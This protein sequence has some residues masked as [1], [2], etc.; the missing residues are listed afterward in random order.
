[1]KQ[2]PDKI[3]VTG[4]A[5]FI[6]STL[7]DS[8]LKNGI[9]VVGIDNFSNLYDPN[10]KR[11]NI[12]QA[13]NRKN[14]TLYVEDILNKDKMFK[15]VSRESPGIVVHIAG[16]TG[17]KKSLESPEEF[18]QT[19]VTGTFNILEVCRKSGISKFIYASTAT[20]Y[21]NSKEKIKEDSNL[22]EPLNTY[23]LTKKMG[24]DLVRY[25]ALNYQLKAM[26]LRLSTVYGP[27]QRTT[28]GIS[29]FVRNIDKGNE[30]SLIGG[31]TSFRDY[32]FIDDCV[33][34]FQL[35]I[36]KI[37]N[38]DII[39]ICGKEVI[40][41][42][43]LIGICAKLLQKRAIIKINS[44]DYGIPDGIL[45]DKHKAEKLLGYSPST[46]FIDGLQK[47]IAYY[48]LQN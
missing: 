26:V 19:N 29:T 33:N 37:N 39:N 45:M 17:M 16:L 2:I 10:I 28:M 38:F 18:Y 4:A 22:P 48:K 13:V 12:R 30:I 8:L 20:V 44:A 31:G 36:E 42:E 35:A 32:V 3:L 41:L 6:G 14:F 9:N 7:C 25:F 5:G 15:I 21:G 23:A 43:N 47:Y 1:M 34:A 46:G 11:D 27:R 24:E 40:S